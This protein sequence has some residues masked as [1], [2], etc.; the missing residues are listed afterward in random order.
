MTKQHTIED[1]YSTLQRVGG[2]TAERHIFLCA[3]SEKQ[4]CCSKEQGTAAW[5]FLKRRLSE[6]NLV[7][8]KRL[9]ANGRTIGGVLRTKADCF[10]ICSHGPIAVIWPDRVWYHSAT[11]EVLEQIIQQHLIGGVPVKKY[12]LSAPTSA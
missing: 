8:P 4:K 12:R 10:Q 11:E 5:N 6:L 7:G 1:A 2:E 3:M 9:D